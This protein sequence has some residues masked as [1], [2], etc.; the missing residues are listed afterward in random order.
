MNGCSTSEILSEFSFSLECDSA[1]ALM[2]KV[3]IAIISLWLAVLLALCISKR[4]EMHFWSRASLF[5]AIVFTWTTRDLHRRLF[6]AEQWEEAAAELCVLDYGADAIKFLMRARQTLALVQI[7]KTLPCLNWWLQIVKHDEITFD[8]KLICK[9]CLII[10]CHVTFQR[11]NLNMACVE[12]DN[13]EIV[14]LCNSALSLA[15]LFR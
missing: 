8:G 9:R 6:T 15:V 2:G 11:G 1:S 14:E 10:A 5:Q 3:N 4:S 12:I 7:S 13:H